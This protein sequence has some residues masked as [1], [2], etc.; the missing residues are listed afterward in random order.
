MPADLHLH[1]LVSDGTAGPGDVVR[2][3]A[4]SG[5]TIVAIA[6]H[7]DA[8]GSVAAR[9]AGKERGVAVVSAIELTARV[10]ARPEGTVH[11][12]GY[13]IDPANEVLA[14]TAR[15]NRLGKR[16]QI[17]GMLARLRSLGI[18][19]AD[20]DVGLD[21]TSDAYVGR[22]KIA[23]ALVQRGLAKDRLKAFKRYLNPR[24]RGWVDPEVVAAAEA[25]ASIHA[26]GG[27]AVLAHPTS[28]DLDRHLGKLCEM[29]LDGIEVYR[30][31]AQGGLL[32]RL[33]KA[34]ERRKLLATG[35]SDW[36]GLYPSIPLG[37]W[38]VEDEKIR[39][40]LERVLTT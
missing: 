11:L 5:L 37:Q 32:A 22:N 8:G 30:P 23:S 35:G 12:L 24:T 19:I 15:K 18:P 9:E 29:G 21:R 17:E 36:H 6:D 14:A 13:R 2:R 16:A 40:F 3:A 34:A 39:P 1:S 7:D 26:A 25:I 27:L 10:D 20:D 33:E 28:E 4:E 38:K 31:R